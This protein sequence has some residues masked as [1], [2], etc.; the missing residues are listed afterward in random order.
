MFDIKGKRVL[1]FIYALGESIPILNERIKPLCVTNITLNIRNRKDTYDFSAGVGLISSNIGIAEVTRNDIQELKGI[2][3]FYV[4]LMLND[5]STINITVRDT[6]GIGKYSIEA[7]SDDGVYRFIHSNFI[8]KM[9]VPEYNSLDFSSDRVKC[10][11][12]PKE[13]H[14]LIHP[15]YAAVFVNTSDRN[16]G[17]L[18]DLADEI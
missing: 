8:K 3:E 12:D 10:V 15:K 11:W 1:E 14:K 2:Q 4:G 18:F 16:T 6:L 13:F 17:S 9:H 7:V 5:D